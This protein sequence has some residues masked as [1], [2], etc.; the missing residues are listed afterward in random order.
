MEIETHR[1]KPDYRC[2]GDVAA[3]YIIQIEREIDQPENDEVQIAIRSTT[4]CGSDLHYFNHYANGDIKIRE[5]LSQGHEAAGEVVSL[6]SNVKNL[7]IGDRV[8]VEA[9][10][11]CES[12]EH[13]VMRR[14]VST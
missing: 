4:L 6:G 1:N 9:G 13:C 14:C 2:L 5:P 3:N 10:I 11:A 12:C 8:A 7:K